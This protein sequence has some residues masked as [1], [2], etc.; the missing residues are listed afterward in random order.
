MVDDARNS[1][2][3]TFHDDYSRRI[4]GSLSFFPSAFL[5][6]MIYLTYIFSELEFNL[7]LATTCFVHRQ[8]TR[9]TQ[10]FKN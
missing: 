1:F 10:V 9:D 2:L 3:I 4:E 8:T 5:E 6:N 7:P